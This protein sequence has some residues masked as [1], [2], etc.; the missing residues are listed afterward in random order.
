MTLVQGPR[1]TGAAREKLRAALR[2]IGFDEVRFA[3]AGEEQD[4]SLREWL[5]SGHHADMAWM[6]R[7]VEKRTNASVR[8]PLRWKSAAL[9]SSGMAVRVSR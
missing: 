8:I 4:E 6:E 7:T 5:E 1:R 9:V 3:Q 2:G